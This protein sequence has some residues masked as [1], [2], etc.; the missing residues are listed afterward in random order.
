MKTGITQKNLQTALGRRVPFENHIQ[1]LHDRPQD[2]H[3]LSPPIIICQIK[4]PSSA[5]TKGKAFRGPT[6]LELGLHS[7]VCNGTTRKDA[8]PRRTF[9]YRSIRNGSQPGDHFSLVV[10]QYLL[11]LFIAIII[12]GFS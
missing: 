3:V 6:L 4:S 11:F 12:L 5:E 8:A 2:S 1:V 9:A 10:R 7:I